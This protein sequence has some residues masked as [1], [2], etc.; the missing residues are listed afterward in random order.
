MLWLAI[1]TWKATGTRLFHIAMLIANYAVHPTGSKESSVNCWRHLH[2]TVLLSP[3]NIGLVL[4][5]LFIIAGARPVDLTEEAASFDF[6]EAS[7][8]ATG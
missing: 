8:M 6:R 3:L 4:T 2:G 5:I 7:P 1:I